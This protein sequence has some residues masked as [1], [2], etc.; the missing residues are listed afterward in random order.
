VASGL[1]WAIFTTHHVGAT[2]AGFVKVP[3]WFIEIVDTALHHKLVG[4][5]DELAGNLSMAGS[6]AIG[7]VTI[8][9][10][11][12]LKSYFWVDVRFERIPHD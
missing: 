5:L 3:S 1:S 12:S 8:T 9:A 11:G 10:F 2:V 4:G 6:E 7:P